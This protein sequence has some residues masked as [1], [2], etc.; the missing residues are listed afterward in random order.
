MITRFVRG[1]LMMLLMAA[2]LLPTATR[3]A[4]ARTDLFHR[5]VAEATFEIV[6]GCY[7]TTVRVRALSYLQQT[8]PG[9]P[10][11]EGLAAVS[12]LEF[13]TCV[14][15]GEAPIITRNIDAEAPVDFAVLGH[16]GHAT[17]NTTVEGIDYI[18]GESVSLTVDA[19]FDGVGEVLTEKINERTNDDGCRTHL[20]GTVA[21]RDATAS[22]TLTFDNT[23]LSLTQP[24]A[25]QL[26]SQKTQ[27]TQIGCPSPD[28]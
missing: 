25:A 3:A 15:P 4:G 11:K 7:E 26:Q 21:F 19:T 5:E 6:S 23:S 28:A 18:T 14:E 13:Y 27:R 9:A 10:S 24:V 22:G 8:E 2:F 17:L 16:L 1:M 20:H 12:L